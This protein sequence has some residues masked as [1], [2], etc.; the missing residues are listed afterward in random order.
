MP[1]AKKY[2]RVQRGQPRLAP[3]QSAPGSFSF[4][5]SSR[6][7]SP[8]LL[9]EACG[10]NSERANW[11]NEE[12]DIGV[13]DDGAT[14]ETPKEVAGKSPWN[15]LEQTPKQKPEETLKET[16]KQAS[17]KRSAPALSRP[18]GSS[19]KLRVIGGRPATAKRVTANLDSDDEIIVAMKKSGSNSRQIA[20]RLRNEGRVNYKDKTITSRYAR[21]MKA[22][23][24]AMER[25]AASEP[26]QWQEDDVRSHLMA[27]YPKTNL[28][29][30]LKALT[31]A[32][33]AVDEKLLME[34][35]SLAKRKWQMVVSQ[36]RIS[37]PRGIF[38][39][40]DCE[41]RFKRLVERN[42]SNFQLGGAPTGVPPPDSSTGQ[43]GFDTESSSPLSSSPPG[44]YDS[45]HD[46]PNDESF[47][48]GGDEREC[49]GTQS[50]AEPMKKN[51]SPNV[52]K[53]TA[54]SAAMKTAITN[55][56]RRAISQKGQGNMV[57]WNAAA[58][59]G[60]REPRV[61]PANVSTPGI[62]NR[63]EG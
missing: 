13:T 30:Q 43:S 29:S 44:T 4:D 49:R 8:S 14:F 41:N 1:K 28:D 38:S 33:V 40:A 62:G 51:I 47:G 48:D 46:N 7:G 37:R 63:H 20:D 25:K 45:V 26:I 61:S 6:A 57:T 12:T 18:N 55:R 21:I 9:P 56:I 19:A 22:Q 34:T 36:L 15:A 58:C 54:I 27:T 35:E 60:S 23:A 53:P 52:A 17:K 50:K 5:V 32:V 31:Q 16:P 42:N 2:G 3:G 10:V 59:P 39:K 11:T 24:V